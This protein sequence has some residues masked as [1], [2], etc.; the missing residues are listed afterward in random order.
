MDK[1]LEMKLV[2]KYPTVMRDYGGSMYETCMAWGIAVGNGWYDII[3]ELCSKLEPMGI[4]AAQIKEKF[5][6]LRFYLEPYDRKLNP[7]KHIR[8]AEKKAYKTCESCG[9]PGERRSGGWIQV[10][11]D[12][13]FNKE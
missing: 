10:L 8:E 12:E 6:G 11:C 3:D 1:E 7:D 5:G 9:K 2:K 13:C 4:V